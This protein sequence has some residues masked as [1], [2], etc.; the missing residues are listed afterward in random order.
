[1]LTGLVARL[2]AV[3]LIKRVLGWGKT[4][5]TNVKDK[6]RL[7]IEYV[8]I[9]LMIAA[10]ALALTMWLQRERIEDQ[11]SDVRTKLSTANQRLGAVEQVNEGQART[12]ADLRE[13]REIDSR[14]LGGLASDYKRLHERDTRLARDINQL[15]KTDAQVRSYLDEP[16]PAELS[17]VLRQR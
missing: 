8:L 7:I 2:I 11:L 17:R 14:S 15:E 1:M 9:G 16:V 13:L 5:V 6:H 3:P 4:A 10:C 12:I